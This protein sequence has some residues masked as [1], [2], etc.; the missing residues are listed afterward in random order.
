[1]K[2]LVLIVLLIVGAA[3]VVNGLSV[4]HGSHLDR[5]LRLGIRQ[6]YSAGRKIGGYVHDS[7]REERRGYSGTSR[8]T[9]QPDEPEWKDSDSPE[10]PSHFDR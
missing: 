10:R 9:Y 2:K 6:P 5:T 8:P 4:R 1:M 7:V 3:V